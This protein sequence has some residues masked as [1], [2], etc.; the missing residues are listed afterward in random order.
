MNKTDD[1][2]R[3]SRGRPRTQPIGEQAAPVQALDRGLTLLRTLAKDSGLTLTD[4]ALRL[5]MPGADVA[6]DIGEG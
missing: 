2:P 5:G 6:A 3:R 1:L 4:I